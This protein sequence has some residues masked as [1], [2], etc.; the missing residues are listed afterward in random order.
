MKKLQ[1]VAGRRETAIHRIADTITRED[2]KSARQLR[3]YPL[4]CY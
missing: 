4:R 3:L 1:A 2:V